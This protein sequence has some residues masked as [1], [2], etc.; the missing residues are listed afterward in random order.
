MPRERRRLAKRGWRN[1]VRERRS[2]VALQLSIIAVPFFLLLLGSMEISY[3]MYV[4][5]AMNMAVTTGMRAIWTGTAQGPIAS[6]D[7]VTNY[8]CPKMGGMIDCS[9]ISIRGTKL[10]S[11]A[12]TDF[13]AYMKNNSLPSYQV[14]TGT[15]GSLTT[16]SWTTVCT[17]GPGAA[18]LLEIVYAG[19]TFLGG[20]VP[21]WAVTSGGGLVHP[22]YAS[23]AWVNQTGFTVTTVC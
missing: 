5:A 2:T 15:S 11:F 10:A 9:L 7:F 16:N 17:G 19:P 14:G 12:T 18:V 21:A 1:L 4:Q 6:T 22:T 3:D 20:L 13:Y 23:A 8:I